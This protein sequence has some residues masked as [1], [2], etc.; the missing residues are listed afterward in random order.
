MGF[1][2]TGA[3]RPFATQQQGTSHQDST[4]PPFEPTHITVMQTLDRYQAY[5]QDTQPELVIG[6]KKDQQ[7]MHIEIKR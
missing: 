7:E 3:R 4:S 6:V 5:T 1:A 2:I